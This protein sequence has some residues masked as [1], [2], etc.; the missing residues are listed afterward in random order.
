MLN[1]TIAQ[2]CY[3]K[4]NDYRRKPVMRHGK[5]IKK[6]VRITIETQIYESNFRR[7]EKWMRCGVCLLCGNKITLKNRSNKS[8]SF[9]SFKSQNEIDVR[10]G[11]HDLRIILMWREKFFFFFELFDCRRGCN[12]VRLHDVCN[13]VNSCPPFLNILTMLS[14]DDV[15][16]YYLIKIWKSWT[17]EFEFLTVRILSLCT[18]WLSLASWWWQFSVII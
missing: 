4:K 17:L 18:L 15:N 7:Y 1:C 9:H 8:R 13:G 16:Y 3:E 2:I 5:H 14:H 11:M 12:Y 6:R 10:V